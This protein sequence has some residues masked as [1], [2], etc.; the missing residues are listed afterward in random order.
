MSLSLTR[1]LARLSLCNYNVAVVVTAAAASASQQQEEKS[2]NLLREEI[3][4]NNILGNIL[5]WAAGLA[6][7]LAPSG[8]FILLL[9]LGAKENS[10]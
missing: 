5:W 4:M 10:Q 9:W 6:N 2:L 1:R 8:P 3:G 7:S